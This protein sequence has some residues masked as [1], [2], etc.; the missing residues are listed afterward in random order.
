MAGSE[1]PKDAAHVLVV[2]DERDTRQVLEKTLRRLGY[3]VSGAENG[4]EGLKLAVELRPQVILSDIRMPQMD[5]HTLLRRLAAHNLDTAVIVMSA[6]G[7]MDDVIDLLRNGSV[8]YIR[9][10]WAPS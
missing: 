3:E 1:S 10:P 8:D 5:G 7:N 4:E 2:D 9:K 6:H